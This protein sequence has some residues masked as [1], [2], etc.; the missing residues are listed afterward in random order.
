MHCITC[1]TLLVMSQQ[2][3]LGLTRC[4]AFGFVS[5]SFSIQ[6]SFVIIFA[7]SQQKSDRW[8]DLNLGIFCE[9]QFYF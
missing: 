8:I 7:N 9:I 3:T 1:I 6:F 5:Y 4:L 2:P